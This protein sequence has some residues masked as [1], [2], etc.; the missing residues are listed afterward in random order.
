MSIF[1]GIHFLCSSNN[2]LCFIFL[3]MTFFFSVKPLKITESDLEFPIRQ[4]MRTIFDQDYVR[5]V[6]SDLCFDYASYLEC[7]VNLEA[8]EL[9]V[10]EEFVES[11]ESFELLGCYLVRVNVQDEEAGVKGAQRV[12]SDPL[13]L[14][15]VFSDWELKDILRMQQD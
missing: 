15:L 8:L 7:L 14:Y 5:E 1:C 11:L 10:L 3:R 4:E 6:R 9:K 2:R 12:V 13:L